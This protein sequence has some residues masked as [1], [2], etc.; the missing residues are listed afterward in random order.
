M[1]KR[2]LGIGIPV[3][4]GLFLVFGSLTAQPGNPRFT[5]LKVNDYIWIGDVSPRTVLWA[6]QITNFKTSTDFL[7]FSAG[8]GQYDYITMN[9]R[10]AV[11]EGWLKAYGG[12]LWLSSDDYV[13]AD[14]AFGQT[15]V[16]TASATNITLGNGNII[17][18]TGTTNIDSISVSSPQVTG[19]V[20]YLEFAGILTVGDAQN[21]KLAGAFTSSADDVLTLVRIANV[22]YEVSRSA[23]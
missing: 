3:V 13:K 5:N 10:N 2:I 7:G 8:E 20:I 1:I 15:I 11:D 9:W 6:N 23:N 12:S 4:L 21:L 17:Q 14:K 19:S 22:F 16:T 18:V